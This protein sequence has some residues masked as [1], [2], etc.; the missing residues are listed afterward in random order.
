MA[1]LMELP[2]DRS[3]YFQ[4]VNNTVTWERYQDYVSNLKLD[5][6]AS[7]LAKASA[8]YSYRI[9]RRKSQ[10]Q[11]D[12]WQARSRLGEATQIDHIDQ[13]QSTLS[14]GQEAGRSRWSFWGKKSST[15]TVPLTTSGGG[16]LE[17]KSSTANTAGNTLYNKPGLPI[18]NQR[19]PTP[20]AGHS[21]PP[22]PSNVSTPSLNLPIEID[23]SNPDTGSSAVGRFFGKLRRTRP[24]SPSVDISNKD[25]ELTQDDFSFLAEVPSLA[26]KADPAFGDLLSLDGSAK[27]SE[28]ISSL[29]AMLNSKP[30]PLPSQLAPPPRPSTSRGAV[31]HSVNEAVP[32]PSKPS[33]LMDLFGDLDLNATASSSKP[34]PSGNVP[35]FAYPST[36]NP[37]AGALVQRPIQ[38]PPISLPR[39]ETPALGNSIAFDMVDADGFGNFAAA[40]H[41]SNGSRP[42]IAATAAEFDE[43][44]DFEQFDMI[45]SKT[46]TQALPTKSSS[47]TWNAQGFEPDRGL[48]SSKRSIVK[49]EQ[50]PPTRLDQ[51]SAAQLVSEAARNTSQWPAPPS[52]NVPAL[53]P[54]TSSRNGANFPHIGLAPPASASS[55]RASTPLN[56]DFLNADPPALPPPRVNS[57]AKP[58]G[59]MNPTR[60]V[61]Q[62]SKGQ[63]LTASDLSFFDSL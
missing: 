36:S 50:P 33:S 44:G 10:E 37:S 58:L 46:I 4:P 40:S 13:K 6:S 30:M 54:P 38:S 2:D 60:P 7:V 41:G 31:N 19:I 55:S 43:F 21:T 18:G 52:P 51:T 42:N 9:N 29:E 25:L 57:P 59:T 47:S 20:P 53:P 11:H 61:S 14:P 28:Q 12:A 3:I 24:Q 62:L 22:L 56:F 15:P 45:P 48:Y 63:G 32:S 1:R 23:T 8:E 35:S 26:H 16:M 34:A 27:S 17:I 39:H 5:S 49:S